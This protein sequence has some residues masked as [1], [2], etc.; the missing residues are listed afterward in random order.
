[1]FDLRVLLWI[2][3]GIAWIVLLY[4]IFKKKPNQ[5]VACTAPLQK[6]EKVCDWCGH[7]N[8]HIS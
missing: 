4:Q 7:F 2:L 5:C 1:M 3:L 6:D 8:N